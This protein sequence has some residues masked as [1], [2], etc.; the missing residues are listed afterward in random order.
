[1]VEWLRL[2]LSNV[3]VTVLDRVKKWGTR[4]VTAGIVILY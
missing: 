2:V 3:V 4:D 1:M